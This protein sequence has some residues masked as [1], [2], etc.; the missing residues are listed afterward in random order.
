MGKAMAA[1]GTLAH[2][3][4]QPGV[5]AGLVP[6]WLTGWQ[7]R[8]PKPSWVW[9]PLRTV[10]VAV[11]AA[12]AAVL[13]QAFVR[14]VVEGLGTPAPI[15]PTRRLV[16]DGSY[17]YVRNP[18]YLAVVAVIVGQALALGQPGLLTYAAAVARPRPPSPTATRIQPCAAGSAP[19]TRPTG[20][21]CPHGGHAATPGNPARKATRRP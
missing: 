9:T 17:R 16:V 8:K 11:L 2:F 19:R 1:A 21:P 20:G 4:L 18:M 15:A 7:L 5:V 12:G 13:V 10:G 6:W 3:V 14:F